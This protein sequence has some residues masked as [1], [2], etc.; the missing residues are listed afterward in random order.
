V[1]DPI[2]TYGKDVDIMLE[3]KMK[4]KALLQFINSFEKL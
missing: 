2:N 1:N 4:E 3:V